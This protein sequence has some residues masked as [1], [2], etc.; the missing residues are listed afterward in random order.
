MLNIPGLAGI[1]V[2]YLAILGIGVYAAWKRRGKGTNSDEVMLAGRSIGSFV[3]V[4][5]MTGECCWAS[6]DT[7]GRKCYLDC[8]VLRV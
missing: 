8:F 3:G 7:D 4:L 1:I 2:F 5:T 6:T